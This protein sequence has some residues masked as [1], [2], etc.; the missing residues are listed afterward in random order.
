MSKGSVRKHTR[1]RKSVVSSVI[2]SL[3]AS[4]VV[5]GLPS[6]SW[7]SSSAGPSI[8]FLNP[9]SFSSTG[10]RGIVVSNQTP[11]SGPNCCNGATPTYR[12]SAWVANPPPDYSVFFSLEQNTLDLEITN[13]QQTQNGA[14]Q[15]QW[16]IPATVLD[17]PATLHAYIVV[18]EQAVASVDQ[19]VTITREADNAEL[20]YP[21][22]DGYF[23]TYS[24]LA[25][26]LPDKGAATRKK[27][28][29]VV[30]TMYT[31]SPASSYVRAFY[32]T[33]APGTTPK[34]SV[35]GTETVGTNAD[36][37][38][39]C[40]LASTD[41][42]LAVTAVASVINDSPN[43]YDDRFNQSGDALSV[44]NAYAQQP[45]TFTIDPATAAQKVAVEPKSGIFYCSNAAL[46][47]LTDQLGH[48]IASANVDVHATG[49]SDTLKFDT[50]GILTKNQ[51][52]DRADHTEQTA[53][54]CTGQNTSN[55]TPP[56]DA[57]PD[58]QGVHRRFGA[59][60]RKHIETLGG[61]TSDAGTF[62]FK[63][64]SDDPGETDYTAWVD[65]QDDGCLTNDD[66]FLPGELNVTGAIGWAQDPGTP[67]V[68]PYDTPVPCTPGAES[69]SPTDSSPPPAT[70]RSISLAI[71]NGPGAARTLR[72]R[73]SSEVPTCKTSQRVKLKMRRRGHFRTIGTATTTGRGSYRFVQ[74]TTRKHSY[75][76]ITP[77]TSGCER[78]SSPTV[79]G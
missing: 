43:D 69:P 75:K 78:A 76:A 57:N 74:P 68:Q 66:L 8:A 27:P 20:G 4:I 23:G 72:G 64:H 70:P 6:A 41:D 44:T 58:N 61:G 73:I 14:W 71:T 29:G 25:T 50:F 79:R 47:T 51:P 54:D 17:G 12:L 53:Y 9:S 11:D 15:S 40:T 1:S 24:A 13:T 38:V 60:D 34:W 52:P 37:G 26:A 35:C 65:E 63:L 2:V 39:R 19:P 45:T 28:I 33:S 55:G 49:P 5:V 36:N 16:A 56:G 62:S 7:G 42:Q 22:P 18:N 30:D 3:F 21:Q 67:V 59:P 77:A 31:G 48:Q 32:T 10:E 46:V